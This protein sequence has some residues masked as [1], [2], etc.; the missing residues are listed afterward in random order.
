MHG[1]GIISGIEKCDVLGEGKS[2]YVLQMPLGDMK[3]MIPADKADHIGLR[4]VIPEARVDEVRDV[5]EDEPER[6]NADAYENWII[7]VSLADKSELDN[8]MDA[9]AYAAFCEK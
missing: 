8:L 2:Y 3:V 4:D 7:K 6:I 1:A 5:L 9:K